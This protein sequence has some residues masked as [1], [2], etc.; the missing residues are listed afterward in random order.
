MS[1]ISRWDNIRINHFSY[2]NNLIITLNIGFIGFFVAKFD[3]PW[4]CTV[5]AVLILT[6][7][8]LMT[9]FL[10]GILTALN[11]LKDF[12]LTSKIA[13]LKEDDKEI[14]LLRFISKKLGKKSWC[15]LYTQIYSFLI[16]VFLGVI[17]LI[18]SKFP[19]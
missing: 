4:N 18:L 8:S 9:S 14:H 13:R 17:Y 6:M 1:K 5:G 16:G 19:L 10:T 11:R 3:H 2:V 12:R 15:L 7:I